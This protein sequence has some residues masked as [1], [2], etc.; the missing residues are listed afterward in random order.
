MAHS[1]QEEVTCPI[2]LE[3]FY[4]PILLSCDHIF[5]FHCMQRWVL[6]HRDL[7]SACPMCRGMTENPAL[8]EWQIGAL[9][10]LVR[11]H[12]SLLERALHLSKELLRFRED[13]T[14]EASSANPFLVLSDDLRKVQCG[15]MCRNPVED[16][17]RFTYLACVLGAPRFSS[18]CHYW[19]VQVGE[20]KEWTLGICRESVNRQRKRGFSPKHGFW[21]ISLKVGAICTSSV[22][23]ARVPA[24][25]RLSHVGIFLDVD[26]E[27]LKFFDVGDNALIYTHD[28]VSCLEPLRPFFCPELPG[29]GDFGASLKICS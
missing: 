19:E 22:P 17:Q 6:E 25:P 7:K 9:A 2:C 14:L 21:S 8:E 12:S 26:M 13:V 3:I 4:C 1:L 28:H 24:S 10:L 16:P 18:G 29:E 5:C 11:Q 27:E 20:A 23:E 15:R